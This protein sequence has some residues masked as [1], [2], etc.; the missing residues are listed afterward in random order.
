MPNAIDWDGMLARLPEVHRERFERLLR[1]SLKRHVE[2]S[3]YGGAV[4]PESVRTQSVGVWRQ[5][6]IKSGM[7]KAAARRFSYE[8][9]RHDSTFLAIERELMERRLRR[10]GNKTN[11]HSLDSLSF[12]EACEAYRA[13]RPERGAS[14]LSS[15]VSDICKDALDNLTVATRAEDPIVIQVC[16]YVRTHDLAGCPRRSFDAAARLGDEVGRTSMAS[17]ARGDAR[18]LWLFGLTTQDEVAAYVQSSGLV[19]GVLAKLYGRGRGDRYAILRQLVYERLARHED[20][21]AIRSIMMALY[22]MPDPTVRTL[23]RLAREEA[24]KL[25][26]YCGG[27]EFADLVAAHLLQNPIYQVQFARSVELKLRVRENVP[28]TPMEAYPLA[29]TMRRRFVVH[30]GPTNSGKTHMAL[31]ALMAAESGAYLGPLRLLAFEQFERLNREGRACMLLTGEERCEVV[32]ARHVSSTVEMV[33]VHTPIEVAVIDEA[34]MISDP[35]R[36]CHWTAAIL[37]VPAA[38]VHVCCAPHAE[39]VVQELVR[40]CDDD[41][42]IVHHQRLVPL[43]P[44]RRSFVFPHDLQ[45]GDALIVFSRRSVHAVADEVVRVGLKPSLVYGALP[46]DVRHEE[47]RRFDAGETDVVVATDAIGMGMN[48]PIR[49]IVFVE[50]TKWD[51]HALRMLKP[52]EVQQIAGRAGR[53]GRYDHGLFQSTRQRGK[54]RHLYE[55]KVPSITSIP[56][57]IPEDIALVRD[58]SLSEAILQWTAMDQPKPFERIDVSRDLTLLNEVESLLDDEQARNIDIKLKVLALATMAFDERDRMLRSAWR[59]MV[60][61]ELAGRQVDLPIPDGPETGEGLE[62]LEARYR[63]CDLLYS[64]ARTFGYAK[65]LELLTKRRTQISHVIMSVLAAR[66]SA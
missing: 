30:V 17:R 60:E 57:G 38:E 8:R 20:V 3:G 24:G 39:D 61:A 16:D 51:G 43:S 40:L 53:F 10:A 48:L 42:T 1:R 27:H 14:A 44:E 54:M 50:Q 35:D 62:D 31:Q 25:A 63:Y 12:A 5:R 41:L 49:R 15:V 58:A 2:Q 26:S 9:L 37:G 6:A 64:Y 7:S 36:G 18:D 46:Y 23:R 11:E 19:D 13:A 22:G 45:K 59:Q 29:R 47:A 21:K 52:E 55:Q 66:A 65:D 4:V 28:E 33:D 34:Q 56:V 32:G